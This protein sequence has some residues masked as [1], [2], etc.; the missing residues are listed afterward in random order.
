MET[1]LPAVIA[2]A[3]GAA[4]SILS[5][6]LGRRGETATMRLEKGLPLAE[7]IAVGIQEV[8]ALEVALR[9]WWKDNLG[10]VSLEEGEEHFNRHRDGMY[11]TQVTDIKRLGAKR[12]ELRD[13]VTRARVYLNVDDLDRIERY[14]NLAEFRFMTVPY[15][16]DTY[17]RE[18]FRNLSDAATATQREL[19]FREIK[20]NLNR[21][22]E[23]V[24]WW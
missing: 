14:L 15:M 24:H 8:Y 11:E 16:F 4:A 7:Q 23:R 12:N 3:G 21:M 9:R 13:A 17:T 2:V 5:Y 1:L 19:L 20:R 10:H 22:H 18:F 6:F